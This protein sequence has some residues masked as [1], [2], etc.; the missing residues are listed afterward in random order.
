MP[1]SESL[2]NTYQ[3]YIEGQTVVIPTDP[4]ESFR[5]IRE[6]TMASYRA[7][8]SG[9][10][11]TREQALT[12][13]HV[14]SEP[15]GGSRKLAFSEPLLPGAAVSTGDAGNKADDHVPA[16]AIPISDS[17]SPPHLSA[18]RRMKLP[19]P[20]PPPS[21]PRSRATATHS[22]RT[23][24][25]FKCK[26]GFIGD[27]ADPYDVRRKT[28]MSVSWAEGK[29]V[30][31]Q[32]SFGG[33]F[34]KTEV[35]ARRCSRCV[36]SGEETICRVLV[37]SGRDDPFIWSNNRCGHCITRWRRCTLEHEKKRRPEHAVA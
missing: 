31:G 28:G 8:V 24:M 36:G 23:S 26:S 25:A 3:L 6:Q 29:Y 32:I 4:V 5:F 15:N 11:T 2:P 1:I 14:V 33:V 17:P 12:F 18:S 13:G 21:R 20:E 37:D 27:F 9:T 22:Q 7:I 19:Q 10:S 35:Q 16:E 30:D 34:A